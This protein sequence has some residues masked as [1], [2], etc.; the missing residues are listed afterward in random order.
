MTVRTSNATPLHAQIT[1]AVLCAFVCHT[2]A[3][4]ITRGPKI[5]GG[6]RFR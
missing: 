5:S 3:E 1:V 4:M 6:W 2:Q